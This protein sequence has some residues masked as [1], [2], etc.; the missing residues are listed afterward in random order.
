MHRRGAGD[1]M[2]LLRGNEPR[3]A[4][5]DGHGLIGGA[6]GVED[7]GDGGEA[8]GAG[9]VGGGGGGVVAGGGVAAFAT[10]G[11][12][13]G[14]EAV[15]GLGGGGVCCGVVHALEDVLGGGAAVGFELVAGEVDTYGWWGVG[16]LEVW[17]V[18]VVVG[19]GIGWLVGVEVLWRAFL[20]VLWVGK[21]FME[22]RMGRFVIL[23]VGGLGYWE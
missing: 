12:A 11:G 6:L 20:M 19:N 15:G 21:V 16:V 18:V 3:E 7:R 2:S 10:M 4:G 1:R 8:V 17:G 9:G 5:I 23:R 13:E 14:A 22:S